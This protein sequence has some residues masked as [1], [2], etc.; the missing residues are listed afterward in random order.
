VRIG[1][2]ILLFAFALLIGNAAAGFASRLA[3][4]LAL[5]AAAVLCAFAQI[6]SIQRLNTSHFGNPQSFIICYII[7]HYFS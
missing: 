3:G 1:L 4:S 6:L 2:F 7:T 5:T